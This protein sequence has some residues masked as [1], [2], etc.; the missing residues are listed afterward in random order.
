VLA[1]T[2]TGQRVVI[3]GGGMV[4]LETAEYLSQQG[5]QVTVLE[6]LADVALDME[7][8]NRL[9]LLD[10]L[11]TGDVAVVTSAEVKEIRDGEVIFSKDGSEQSLQADTIV[12][13]LGARSN[14]DL[15]SALNGKV[16]M[17]LAVGDCI[18]PRRALE[19]IHE[20]FWVGLHLKP[21]P[22]PEG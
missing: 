19:A 14:N 4:G 2:E 15:L 18:T 10:R 13:A 7:E 5:C 9:V 3:L 11:S 6:M 21:P 8:A 17:L 12:I 22:S 20:G 16:P 1:G